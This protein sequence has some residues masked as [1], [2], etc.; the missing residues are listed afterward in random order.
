[1]NNDLEYN[2]LISND[3]LKRAKKGTGDLPQKGTKAIRAITDFN[4]YRR[5]LSEDASTQGCLGGGARGGRPPSSK[6]MFVGGPVGA[7]KI[8]QVLA[9]VYTL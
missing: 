7:L 9:I 1:M 8:D 6:K 2:K 4:E 3:F 5:R